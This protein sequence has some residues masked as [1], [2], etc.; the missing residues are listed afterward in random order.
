MD[1]TVPPVGAR[2][3]RLVV[4]GKPVHVV[5]N[6]PAVLC[7]CDC[8]A[9]V[10]A[11]LG[12]LRVGDKKSCGCLKREMDKAL[13]MPHRRNGQWEKSVEY[14]TWANMIRRCHDPRNKNY[15][16]YGARGIVVCDRWRQ[17][18]AAFIEDMG[19]KPRPELTIERINNDGHYEPT[20]CRWATRSEQNLNKRQRVEPRDDFANVP[21][22][23]SAK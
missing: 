16:Y 18:L 10:V 19:R 2:F 23:W 4:I 22:T 9:E 13:G 20:N 14:V 21:G 1:R 6:R 7:R 11:R 15:K 12:M 17:S 8:G 3:T 5:H